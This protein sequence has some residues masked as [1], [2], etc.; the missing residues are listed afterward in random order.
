MKERPILFNTDM[1]RAILDGRKTQTRRPCRDQT[2]STYEYVEDMKTWP[3]GKELYTGWVKVIDKV[4]LKIP[5]KCPY[6]VV[7]DRLWVR[8]TFWQ[9]SY[10]EFFYRADHPDSDIR[11][12][13]GWKPSIHMPRYACRTVLEITDI[14]VERIQDISEADAKAEGMLYLDGL[15]VGHSG[16]RHSI[17]HEYVYDTARAAFRILWNSVY[18]KRGYGWDKNPWVWVVE[19]KRI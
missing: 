4:G 9:S 17:N 16:Y 5:S 1:V 2:P 12:H 11:A 6:G 10:G 15:G 3:E 8:E 7:G 14:R 19:F 18:E 13:G